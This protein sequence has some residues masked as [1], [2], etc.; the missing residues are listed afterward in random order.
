VFIHGL[1]LSLIRL[2]IIFVSAGMPGHFLWRVL[3]IPLIVAFVYL[4]AAFGCYAA[5]A[6]GEIL[7][8][9]TK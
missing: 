1:L 4:F 3:G 5:H 8:R 6:I 2:L 7:D 9:K